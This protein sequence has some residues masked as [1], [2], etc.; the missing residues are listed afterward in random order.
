M[1]IPQ[2]PTFAEYGYK[3]LVASTWFGLS[4]PRGLPRDIA[5]K[6]NS[7][8]HDALHQNDV[9]IAMQNLGATTKDL[10]VD[11]FAHFVS[12]ESERWGAIAK[13]LALVDPR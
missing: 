7:K 10:D 6:L 12:G 4:G 2:V 13:P 8:V 5:E 3:N 1:Q 11:G 9:K